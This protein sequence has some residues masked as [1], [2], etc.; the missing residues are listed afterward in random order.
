MAGV[1]NIGKGGTTTG[2]GAELVGCT[3]DTIELVE[4]AGRLGT[5][6]GGGIPMGAVVLCVVVGSNA[7]IE[8]G[9]T[10]EIMGAKTKEL[11]SAVEVTSRFFMES[12]R[13]NDHASDSS[14][15]LGVHDNRLPD[16]LPDRTSA[17]AVSVLILPTLGA[18]MTFEMASDKM[19]NFLSIVV[20]L[21]YKCRDGLKEQ[22]S[23]DA[24]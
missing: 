20:K 8:T 2:A 16:G 13:G 4:T 3:G 23:E 11:G 18:A 21:N 7:V 12:G 1:V 24:Y 6:K 15:D 10:C 5:N 19:K 9:A 14:G 22:E 17:T